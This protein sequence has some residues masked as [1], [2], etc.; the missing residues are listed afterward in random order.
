[1]ARY[2]TAL[3]GALTLAAMTVTPATAQ[4]QTAQAVLQAA[5]Q[6]WARTI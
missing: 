3:L 4:G 5:A 1:M 2:I 6:A